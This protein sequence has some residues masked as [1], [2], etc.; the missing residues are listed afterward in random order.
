MPEFNYANPVN[1]AGRPLESYRDKFLR[2]ARDILIRDGV[3]GF[4]REKFLAAGCRDEDIGT[5]LA[6][7]GDPGDSESIES[8]GK[9]IR[10]DAAQSLCLSEEKISDAV[11]EDLIS[12][13]RSCYRDITEEAR[14]YLTSGQYSREESFQKLEHLLYRH[15]YLCFHPKNRS[16]VLLCM[17]EDHLPEPYRKKLAEVLEEEFGSVLTQLI[18]SGGEIKNEQQASMMSCCVIGS[19][20][21]FIQSPEYC[22]RVWGAATR[23]EPNYAVIEDLVNNYLL[24]SIWNETAAG[25]PF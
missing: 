6:P 17:Q 4:T 11:T 22:R 20:G 7:A 2:A 15:V 23:Q 25:K 13:I 8:A 14:S 18:L 24:R 12:R 16:Y 19:I 1:A 5:F 3:S 9:E 10:P 21:I